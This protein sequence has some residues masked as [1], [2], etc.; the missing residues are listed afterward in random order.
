MANKHLHVLMV[1]DDH[2]DFAIVE[3]LLG[4]ATRTSFELSHVSSFEEAEAC[5]LERK[6]DIFLVDYFLGS[7]TALPLLE[8][9]L[10]QS[11]VR[12]IVVL[13]GADGDTLD[14][15]VI[16][17]GAADFLPKSELTTELLERTIRHA[18]EHKKVLLRLERLAKQ[19]AL[20]GL[21]NRLLFEEILEKTLARAKRNQGKLAVLFLDLDRFKEINDS[22]GHPT[23][24]LLLLLVADRLRKLMRDSDV[25]ARIGGDEFTVLLDDL[26]DFQD[27]VLVAEKIIEC[28]GKPSAIRGNELVVSASVGIAVY[29]DNGETPIE[30]MQKA[31][32]ALYEAKRRGAGRTQFFTAGLQT[33]LENNLEI[34]R[35]LRRALEQEAL[36]LFLQPKWMLDDTRILGF[37]GLLRWRRGDEVIAPDLFIPVAER[38]GL[39]LPLGEWV[40]DEACAIL[41]L[42]QDQGVD[43]FTLAINVSP[44]QLQSPSFKELLFQTIYR[45][46]VDPKRLELELTEETLIDVTEEEGRILTDLREIRSM[47]IRVAIDDFGTGYSSLR[48]LKHFPAEYL[49]IDRSFVSGEHDGLSEPAIA[50]AVVTL[51]DSLSLDSVAEGVETEEQRSLLREMGCRFGQGYLVA[52]PKPHDEALEFALRH[53]RTL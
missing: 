37:E 28:L 23:G 3:A 40:I 39:I 41:S 4:T 45:H 43:D 29:P 10:R 5:L 1:D 18:V 30:L 25:I 2:A 12:P 52:P 20:T 22:L 38:T 44:I 34:E 6:Y 49:K 19:D 31:D 35:G 53:N 17:H 15:V 8:K 16:E 32:I 7:E 46:G 50:K 21:G 51:S 11:V 24:D 13:T 14:D 33:Q 26:G 36:E 42:W 9:A 47:G 48:Y 27:A